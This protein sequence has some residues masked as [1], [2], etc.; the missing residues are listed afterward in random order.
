MHVECPRCGSPKTIYYKDK[1]Q[2]LCLTCRRRSKYTPPSVIQPLQPP[3]SVIKPLPSLVAQQH[4]ELEIDED[5]WEEI[6]EEPPVKVPE[7][8]QPQLAVPIDGKRPALDI[9]PPAAFDSGSFD[10][11]GTAGV[12]L[13][14]A[15]QSVMYAV[16][17]GNDDEARRQLLKMVE[18][19]KYYAPA[20][21]YLASLARDADEQRGYLEKAL[22]VDIRNV[23][24]QEAL[25]RL[26]GRLEDVRKFMRQRVLSE[27]QVAVKQ[28]ACPKCGGSLAY[29]EGNR[30]VRCQSCGFLV[31]D[32]DEMERTEKQSSV[33]FGL[34]ERKNAGREW[35]IGGRWI[36]C[37]A[38]GATTTLTR[39]LKSACSFCGSNHLLQENID[40]RF[41]QP[42]QILP[43]MIDEV[44]AYKKVEE[45]L[46][47]GIRRFT[48]FFADA[49]ERKEL[50][51]V[52]LPFWIF[53]ADL[54]V[55]YVW[56]TNPPVNGDYPVILTDVPY[57]AADQPK[58][59]LVQ[60][61]E[62][63]DVRQ[64][65][66]Y[67]P[68]LL[69]N[70][71]AE[72]YAEDID[73]ASI[74]VRTRLGKAAERHA[75]SRV[76]M[77]SNQNANRMQLSLSSMTDYLSYRFMLLPVWIGKLTEDDGDVIPVLVNGQSGKVA[78]G[79]TI[80]L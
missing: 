19:S 80:S 63:F 69:A 66:D 72:L 50:N 49:I 35:N 13:R 8:P 26:D 32:A 22:A 54:T 18:I 56:A 60:Q 15:A 68:R 25:A 1:E 9:P 62:P 74:N 4:A 10:M 6:I 77:P 34:L 64:G 48:R 47:S 46:Q 5:F 16:A 51:P 14:G 21:M 39:E 24:A 3:P 53:D 58:R 59:A 41:E 73:K 7:Q 44:T 31:L 2:V 42:D 57:L 29:T 67:D 79:K 75:R 30:E 33:T 20:W 61:I 28:M 43:F 76:P 23:K 40:F 55:K 27:G 17:H 12:R 38:C 11:E 70:F 52:Y 65:V 45:H 71:P 36:R 37:E 78:L